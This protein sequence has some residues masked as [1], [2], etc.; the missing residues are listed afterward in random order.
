MKGVPSWTAQAVFNPTLPLS[1]CCMDGLSP[2]SS[3]SANDASKKDVPIRNV[4]V[5]LSYSLTQS[6]RESTSP[7]PRLSPRSPSPRPSPVS[8][9]VQTA[10]TASWSPP[11]ASQLVTCHRFLYKL[12][13]RALHAHQVPSHLA[14]CRSYSFTEKCPFSNPWVS[15][16]FFSSHLEGHLL[17]AFFLISQQFKN[18]HSGSGRWHSG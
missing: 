4:G 9:T 15:S 2:G 16:F 1:S 13:A 6:I 12:L 5:I 14:M 10:A 7:Q 18:G 8:S 17:R 3:N 11:M